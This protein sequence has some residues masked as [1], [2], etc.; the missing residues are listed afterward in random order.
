MT[1]VFDGWTGPSA[2]PRSRSSPERRRIEHTFAVRNGTIKIDSKP[3]E[4]QADTATDVLMQHALMRRALAFDQANLME[5]TKCLNWTDKL[6]KARLEKPPSGFERPSNKQLMAADT[7]LFEERVDLTRQGI[8][9]TPMGR[10]LD[11]ILDQCKAM[12]E[13][14]MLLQLRQFSRAEATYDKVKG[15]RGSV[16]HLRQ[17][18]GKESPNPRVQMPLLVCQMN[19]LV[20]TPR[21]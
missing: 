7:K 9:P 15:L 5:F 16:S 12:H 3:Q 21:R 20:A 17:E 4:V 8:R 6:M 1:I 19:L 2:H 11:A 13:V 14:A 10:P 18:R